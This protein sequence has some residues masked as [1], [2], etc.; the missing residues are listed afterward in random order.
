MRLG[1]RPRAALPLAPSLPRSLLLLLLLL[2]HHMHP[3]P[4]TISLVHC[5]ALPPRAH[6]HV[7]LVFKHSRSRET[8]QASHP[9][10]PSLRA[11]HARQ[12]WRVGLLLLQG[13]ECPPLRLLLLLLPWW[14]RRSAACSCCC[15]CCGDRQRELA[16]HHA[17]VGLEAALRLCLL[18]RELGGRRRQPPRR[19]LTLQR[20]LG[21]EVVRAWGR[22]EWVGDT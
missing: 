22:G 11:R 6:T 4:Q 21:L 10:P 20:A 1:G 5:F 7:C 16:Q 3:T 19:E 9:P 18:P 13:G 14:Q 15:C 2:Y 17:Q 8:G 12:P